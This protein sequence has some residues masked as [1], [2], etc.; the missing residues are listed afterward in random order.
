MIIKS[1]LAKLPFD[2][3]FRTLGNFSRLP[4]ARHQVPNEVGESERPSTQDLKTLMVRPR[5]TGMGT[6][7][8]KRRRVRATDRKRRIAS[9]INQRARRD[10]ESAASPFAP[11]MVGD[12]FKA[13]SNNSAKQ[14]RAVATT[15][16][17]TPPR[18]IKQLKPQPGLN[19]EPPKQG[20]TQGGGSGP[21]L[22]HEC[23]DR[24]H[25]Q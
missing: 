24:I 15:V 19:K 25:K 16:L 5:S 23:K 14:G 17:V 4:W 3:T 1:L 7:W 12:L 9:S 6:T 18:M 13:G 21:G 2:T 22:L 10:K 11:P 8:G 20:S